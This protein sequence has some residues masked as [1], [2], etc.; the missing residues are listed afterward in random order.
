V[1]GGQE[2][3]FDL[4]E[5]AP[6]FPSAVIEQLR[7]IEPDEHGLRRLPHE[8]LPVIVAVRMSLSVP[9]LFASVPLHPEPGRR[10]WFTD[11]GVTS[12]FPISLFDAWLPSRPTF[13]ID[14]RPFPLRGGTPDRRAAKRVELPAAR[15]PVPPRWDDVTGVS[16]LVQQIVDAVQNWRDSAQAELDGFRDRVCVL[17][18]GEGEGGLHLDMDAATLRQLVQDGRDAGALLSERFDAAGV[19]RHF[20]ARYDTLG[21][22]LRGELD[23]L[24]DPFGELTA[25]L[26][27]WASRNGH[28]PDLGPVAADDPA[29]MR[30]VPR[31]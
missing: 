27:C 28:R 20:R 30:I 11:G 26:A 21:R 9:L 24:E 16:T 2:Y 18:L 5:L 13:G 19:R 7:R 29:D 4:R 8:E 17:R 25:M 31:L 10:S 12:N 22:A 14:M 6:L 23:P 15:G 1:R 3:R